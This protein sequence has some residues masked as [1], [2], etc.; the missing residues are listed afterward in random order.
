MVELSRTSPVWERS[1]K[2]WF[3]VFVTSCVAIF[4]FCIQG[5]QAASSQSNSTEVSLNI[6]EA[7]EV[8]SWPEATMLL[9][10][11]AVPGQEV[12]SEALRFTVRCN[13]QWGIQVQSDETNGKLR[14]YNTTT[15]QYVTDGRESQ[16]GVEWGI[17]QNGPWTPLSST[18]TIMITNQAATGE[19]GSTISFYLRY[20]PG[21]NDVRLGAD[22]IYRLVLT[23]TA[24]VGY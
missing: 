12:V 9:T 10:S 16:R 20:L 14:E 8:V 13:S 23:Y 7:I 17:T 4:F 15:G 18:P 1:L 11:N 22:R 3:W 21:F 24:A 6:A 5:V 19:I 2:L